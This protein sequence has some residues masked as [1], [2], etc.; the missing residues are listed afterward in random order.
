[1]GKI[2]YV[3]KSNPYPPHH[4]DGYYTGRRYWF[5]GE[6]Y[7][8]CD[9]IMSNAKKYSSKSRAERACEAINNS[10]CNYFFTVVEADK[11]G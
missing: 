11:D 9:D 7:A 2:V 1:M 8:C 5:L 3:L 4:W 10:V 6:R